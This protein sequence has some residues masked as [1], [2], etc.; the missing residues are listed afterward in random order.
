MGGNL[1]C[2][3]LN[4]AQRVAVRGFDRMDLERDIRG[5]PENG[6]SIQRMQDRIGGTDMRVKLADII[7]DGVT[8]NCV[9]G[10]SMLPG[11]FREAGVATLSA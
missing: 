1:F 10:N 4:G 9:P 8:F 6:V 2:D 3:Q 11:L 7:G 5:A